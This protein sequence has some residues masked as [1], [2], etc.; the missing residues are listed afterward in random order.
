[1]I[2]ALQYQFG[3]QMLP[4]LMEGIAPSLQQHMD[5]SDNMILGITKEKLQWMSKF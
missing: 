1:M 5:A 4:S 3:T 2:Y